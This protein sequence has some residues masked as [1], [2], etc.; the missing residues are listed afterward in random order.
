MNESTSLSP[1]E[2]RKWWVRALLMLLMAIA[3]HIA[4]SV[5]AIVALVQLVLFAASD[6]PHERL[7]RLGRGLGRYLAQIAAFATF[8]TDALPFPFADWPD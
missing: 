7:R 5:L 6:Q 4:A 3:F 1:V 2:Q 8:D